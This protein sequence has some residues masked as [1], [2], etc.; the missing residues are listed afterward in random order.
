MMTTSLRA[1]T[2]LLTA[3]SSVL[4][5]FATQGARAATFAVTAL[6]GGGEGEP[7]IALS[8]DGSVFVNAPRG[9]GVIWHGSGA[10]WARTDNFDRISIGT[11]DTDL[12]VAPDD[13]TVY[14]VNLSNTGFTN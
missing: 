5:L 11:G 10:S 12:A 7:G 13:G 8:P 3:F 9:T 1:R 4:L 6:P 2:A 14:A